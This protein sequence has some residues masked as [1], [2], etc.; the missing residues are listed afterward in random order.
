MDYYIQGDA[1]RAKEIKAAFEAKGCTLYRLASNC[2]SED[3]IYYSLNG[4]VRGI[5]KDNLY[6][7]EAHPG[8]KELE[9][10]VKP[11]FKVGDWITVK[12]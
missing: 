10:P 12:E 4:I 3:L 8:Y 2:D 1:A 11:K 5:K 6:L 9:L 7:F